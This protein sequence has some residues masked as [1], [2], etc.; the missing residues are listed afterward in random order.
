MNDS[1][2]LDADTPFDL[3][4]TLGCGQA[5]RWEKGA[6]GTWSGTA[7]GRAVRIRQDGETL[8]FS[9]ADE[10]F[11][12]DYFALD[13][14]LNEILA[15]IDTDPTIHRAVASCT[16]LRLLRQEPFETLISYICATNTNI[17]TVKKRVRLLSERYGTPLPGGAHAF[18]DAA[19]LAPCSEDALRACVLGYRA[20]YICTTARMCAD[21]PDWAARLAGLPYPEA[22]T[23]LLRFPGV[24]PKAADCILLFAFQQ[25]EAFPV[26]V[27]IRRI[28][29]RAYLPHLNE[30]GGMSPK[31]YEE[32]ASFARRHFGRYAGWAQEYLYCVR[33]DDR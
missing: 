22:K 17:P 30:S 27:W 29:R 10:A 15:S 19:A 6:D 14:D 28:M 5:F 21:D 11:V 8:S 13:L 24:G 7:R 20:P 32:I 33:E 26:D 4:A 2:V 3:D 25:Y 23:E 16:G 18:P 9:G 12:T 1:I 31:E